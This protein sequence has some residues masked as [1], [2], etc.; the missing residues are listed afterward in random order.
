MLWKDH[1][2]ENHA[3]MEGRKAETN[4]GSAGLTARA[5]AVAAAIGSGTPYGVR[6]HTLEDP[7][8]SWFSSL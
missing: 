2:V 4:L 5:T 6:R 1:S 7:D 3:G 8:G